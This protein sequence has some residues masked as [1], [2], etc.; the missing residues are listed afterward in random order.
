LPEGYKSYS[1]T[2]TIQLAEFDELKKWWQ[3]REENEQ[4]WQ[5]DIKTIKENGYN[6]DIKNPYQPEP[7][8]IY[9]SAELL[10]LL[11]TSFKKSDNL[12]DELHKEL[13]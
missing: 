11:K 5:V 13:S 9:S 4:A 12:L 3:K 8:K 10:T 1:K 6:L 2:K 7:E